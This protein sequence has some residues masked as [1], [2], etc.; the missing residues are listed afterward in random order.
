MFL[1]ESAAVVEWSC[2]LDISDVLWQYQND[3]GDYVAMPLYYIR[4]CEE[5][6]RAGEF[7]FSY[8]HVFYDGN[9]YYTYDV[10]LKELTQKNR[11]TGTCRKIRRLVTCNPV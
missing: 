4:K 1:L 5:C 3:L 11:H 10:N 9:G 8:D 2:R 6:F 7:V